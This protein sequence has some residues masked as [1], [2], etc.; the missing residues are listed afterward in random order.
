MSAPTVGMI[1][2]GQ[3]AQ[4]SLAPAIALGI[5]LKILAADESDSAAKIAKVEIGDYRDLDVLRNFAKKCD[6]LTF[7]HELVPN[8]HLRA[9]ESEGFVIRPSSTSLLVAQDKAHMR[10]VF[11]ENQIPCP[12]WQVINS[13]D[14]I[15]AFPA[16][17]K[18]ITGGYDG[19]GVQLVKDQLSARKVIAE[20]GKAL[21]EEVVPFDRELAILI[22]RSPHNQVATWAVSETI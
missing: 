19:R 18:S 13:A 20:W 21:Y 3:L 1:G 2:A 12:K 11:T 22:A 17:L 8:G 14:A 10:K 5:N 9:L 7:E 6:F 4:M 15:P 16:I